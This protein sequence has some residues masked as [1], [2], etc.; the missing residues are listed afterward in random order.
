[1]CFNEYANGGASFLPAG[2]VLCMHWLHEHH[3]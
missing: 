2:G 1:M 3:E